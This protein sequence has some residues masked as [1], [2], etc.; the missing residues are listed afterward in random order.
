[1]A[2]RAPHKVVFEVKYFRQ[3]QSGS[4]ETEL[5]KGIYEAFFYRALPL[6]LETPK[7]APWD[8][9]YAC[10]LAYDATEEG[11]LLKAW[12]SLNKIVRKGFWDG[13]NIYIMILRSRK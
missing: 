10:L 8:Y 2:F 1:M 5:V 4:A 6:I 7:R 9:D 11:N 3:N 12:N 13:A